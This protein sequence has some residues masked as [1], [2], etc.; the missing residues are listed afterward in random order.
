MVC[1]KKYSLICFREIKIQLPCT[2]NIKY[3]PMRLFYGYPL[4]CDIFVSRVYNTCFINLTFSFFKIIF[5]S[6]F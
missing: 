2:S 6:L 1:Q 3:I 4:E 5:S